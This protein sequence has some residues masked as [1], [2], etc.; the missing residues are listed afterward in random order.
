MKTM[1]ICRHGDDIQAQSRFGITVHAQS[2]V[3]QRRRSNKCSNLQQGRQIDRRSRVGRLHC[4]WKLN[5]LDLN[6][7]ISHLHLLSSII[8]GIFHLIDVQGS[9]F[10]IC[11]FRSTSHSR[12]TAKCC[13]KAIQPRWQ[14]QPSYTQ[15]VLNLCGRQWA[16]KDNV[17][18]LN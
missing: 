13:S 4:T 9:Q 8:T 12:P 7:E 14:K 11:L 5:C 2:N 10:E 17:D 18:C 3:L 16:N 6:S 1:E 15:F